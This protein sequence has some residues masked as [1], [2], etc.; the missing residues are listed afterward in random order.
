MRRHQLTV[1]AVL[2]LALPSPASAEPWYRGRHGNN[3]VLHLSISTGLGVAYLASETVL[4]PSLAPDSCRWC[5][6]PGIDVS[7]RDSL[8]WRDT[9]SARL[10]S[11]L[12]GY[13]AVPVM[14]IGITALT[15]LSAEDASWGRLIDDTIPIFETVAI[16]QMVTQIA[17]WSLARQRPFVHYGSSEPDQDDNMSF[18]SGHSALAFGVTTSAGMVAHWRGSASEPFIWGIG[19]PLSAAAGYFRIAGDKHYFTDVV[20]GAVVGVAAGLTI[21]RLMR[22]RGDV[23][24]VPQDRGAAIVGSF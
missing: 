18:W 20:T 23:M 8:L 24:L 15:A 10:F 5:S 3:R 4:K 22:R 16:S 14:G 12:T 11:H 9:E 1:L 2:V 19:L 7:V 17:K 6:P 21:P 13:V